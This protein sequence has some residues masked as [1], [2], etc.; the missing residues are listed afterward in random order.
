MNINKFSQDSLGVHLRNPRW[1]WGAVDPVSDRVFL[2]VWEDQT[3]PDG[4]GEKVQVYWK[5]RRTNSPGYAEG[6]KHLEAIRNGAQGIGIVTKAVDPISTGARQIASF[7]DSPLLQLGAF[8]EDDNGIYARITARIP[9]SDLARSR[10]LTAEAKAILQLLV[11]R[12][13]EGRFLPDDEKSFMGYGEAHNDLGLERRGPH[14][15]NSLRMQGLANL[16]EWLH[17]NRLPEI[18]G[19]IVDQTSF[20]PGNGYFEVNGR[21]LDDRAWWAEQIRQAIAFDWSTY[22]DDDTTPTVDELVS[23][24]RAVVEGTVN[25]IAVEVRS[26]CEALRKRARQYYRSPDGKLRCEIC[27][28]HKPDNRISGDIVELHHIRPLAELPSDGVRLE[29]RKAIESLVPLCPCGHRIAHS[30]IGGR[31]FTLDELRS[32][33]P[34]YPTIKQSLP[35]KPLSPSSR[36]ARPPK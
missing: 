3:Q 8:S 28:W 22:V 33:I 7:Q 12:I 19:L 21:P 17:Q 16:A 27:E 14:W 20:Q 9:T 1:S 13:R 24:T 34:K 31:S 30:R 18:T 6:L 36:P 10:T 35:S 5:K 32:I 15:G 4:D 25:S 2:R 11:N 23:Y 29:L 26:R